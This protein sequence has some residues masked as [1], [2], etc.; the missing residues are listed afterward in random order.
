MDTDFKV[1]NA[2]EL[3]KPRWQR[4]NELKYIGY[5]LFKFE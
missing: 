2:E 4:L 1:Y 5:S 3:K